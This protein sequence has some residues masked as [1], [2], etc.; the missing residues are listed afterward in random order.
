V[1]V[2]LSATVY[3][4]APAAEAADESAGGAAADRFASSAVATLE[5][6]VVTAGRRPEEIETVPSS[7][8]A[9]GSSLIARVQAGSLADVA[10]YV[11]GLNVQPSGVDANRLIIRGLSTGPNDLSPTVGVYVDD[12]PFGSNSGFALGALFS[13]DVDPFDLD[14]V[15]VLRGPQGTLYGASTLAG[16]V[17][18]VTKAP[19]TKTFSTHARVD[20]GRA[21]DSGMTTYAARAGAN[22]PLLTDKVAL[23]VSGFYSHADG[24]LTD[25][26]TG[27]SGLNANAKH[28][29]RVDLLIKP[30]EALSIDL[31]AFTDTNRTPRVG[32]IDANAQTLLPNS[33]QYSG[34]NYVIGFSQ[35]NY[36]V[37]EGTVRY[38]FANGMTATS[39]TSYSRFAVNALADDTTVFQPAFGPLGAVLEFP[40]VVAPTTRKYTQ[41][42]RLASASNGHF[43]WLTGLFF[44]RENSEYFSSLN[45]TYQFGAT[46]PAA[47]AP[48]LAALAN[49]EAVDLFE[50]YTEYAG[51]AD[52][53]YYL[54]PAFDLSA[55][56]R[57]S[58]NSQERSENG[59][60]F[61]AQ[62][63]V[64]PSHASATSADGVWT[65][66]LAARWHLKDESML[67]AR[68]ATGYRPGGPNTVGGSFAPDKTSNYELGFKTA[69]LG[70]VLRADVAA[71]F[72]DW[73]RIQL[74]FFNGTNT[75]IG[76]AGN[77][78]SKGVEL[79]T[80]YA[81]VKAF[82]LQ[83]NAAYTDAR[84]SS[85]IAGA[86]GGAA[87][88]D[89]LP[90][91]SK[92][93]AS[94]LADY[95][96]PVSGAAEWNAGLGLRYRSS[97]NTTFPGDPGTRFYTLPATVFC[98]L[99][100]GISFEKIAL[101]VQV[102]N[103]ANQRKVLTASEYLA[104][105]QAQADA[106]GQPAYLSYTPGRTFGLSL[107]AQF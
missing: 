97:S 43:E 77:A 40:G 39:T 81:P 49:Y 16:L 12:A 91:N 69:G 104:V 84:I 36:S 92:W 3:A 23:R 86:Q 34:Y 6:V 28:G 52:A 105:S 78:H 59:S 72:I 21:D 13:P 32:Q 41:E 79:Q 2:A 87:V 31:I 5:E 19:D 26:R 56:L 48:T 10:A 85:L 22:L 103:V 53:T 68:Y 20:V 61:L 55:G 94:L 47:L 11:P 58:H 57:F 102:H 62:L 4:S 90:G 100:T 83:A 37:Y 46:P 35:S 38:E 42:L 54:T 67:Y 50:H 82:T 66:S 17:K 1:V 7:V 99:R 24:E 27:Q 25:T 89:P 107:T 60:G 70:G 44:D 64:I 9:I 80:T 65:E 51:F 8:T 30:I 95:Y 98:D 76:N 101:N 74:N 96:V 71:F 18:Y 29:G 45:S 106:A 63:G 14:R 73:R 33:G 88:G 15:E 75:I 93:T